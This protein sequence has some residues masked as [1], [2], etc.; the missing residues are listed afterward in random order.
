[1]NKQLRWRLEL[2]LF[3]GI[4]F[5]VS[6]L[7]RKACLVVGQG[8]G[9]LLYYIDRRHRKTAHKNLELVLGEKHTRAERIRIAKGSFKHFGRLAVDIIK[10]KQLPHEKIEKLL[11][12]SGKEHIEN[13]IRRGQ[14]VLIFTAHYGNW[15]VGSILIS[16]FGKLNVIAR[17][18]DNKLLEK[19]LIRI[20]ENFGVHVIYKKQ[21]TKQVLQA[22]RKNEM[23]AILIDQNVLRSEAVFV[24]FFGEQAATTPSIATFHLRTQAPLVPMF[25]YPKASGKYHIQAFPPLDISLSGDKKK[26][27]IALTQAC[28]KTIESQIQKNPTLWLWFHDRWKSKP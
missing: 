16:K 7:P 24:D 15:E 14:G 22:L 9:L 10:L 18:S 27:I 17:E 1:M 25:C 8:L 6:I 20:R 28:T 12:L 26:D 3:Y 5:F 23:V 21:A 19:K 2:C 13:A 11:T 4:E